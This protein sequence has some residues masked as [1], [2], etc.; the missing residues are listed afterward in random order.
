MNYGSAIK[1][2]RKNKGWGQKELA[3]KVGMSVNAIS[4]IESDQTTPQ[5][6]NLEAIAIAL[7]IPMSFLL[8]FSIT[9]EDVPEEKRP[10]FR[11]IDEAMRN[12]LLSS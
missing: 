2:W 5:K 10:A 1:T 7:E 8:Y 6:A 11:H 12:L 3:D 4:L 9:E